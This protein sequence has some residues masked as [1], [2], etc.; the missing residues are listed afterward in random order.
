MVGSGLGKAVGGT[1]RM[2]KVNTYI[3]GII[4]RNALEVSIDKVNEF[5]K[6]T[7]KKPGSAQLMIET[8]SEFSRRAQ[9]S[10]GC[11]RPKYCVAARFD[12]MKSDNTDCGQHN[13]FYGTVKE[14]WEVQFSFRV[15][16][17]RSRCVHRVYLAS[18]DWQYGLHDDEETDLVH[19]NLCT[20]PRRGSIMDKVRT[21]ESI[22]CIDRLIGFLDASGRRFYLDPMARKLKT[23]T[24]GL[25]C[26]FVVA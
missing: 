17:E 19:T 26:G 21:V 14:I 5:K 7:L 16:Q 13:E 3:K 10:A 23:C 11:A 8:E 12:S 24:E 15:S 2:Q 9:R 1:K 6:V 22:W 4:P 18:F 25:L 20:H